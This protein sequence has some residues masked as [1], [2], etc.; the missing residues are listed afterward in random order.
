MFS[1]KNKLD[2]ELKYSLDNNEY[3]SYRVLI[4]YK[5]LK[6]KIENKIN[7]YKGNVFHNISCINT[8][9]ASVSPYTLNRLIEHPEIDYICFDKMAL[10]CGEKQG[11]GKAN[12]ISLNGNYRLTGKGIGIGLIDTGVYPHDDL[13]NPYKKVVQFKD[14][15]NGCKYPYDDN[16]HGTFISGLLCGSGYKSDGEFKGIAENSHIYCIKAFNA[17]GR[18]FVSDILFSIQTLI[19]ESEAH[20]IR[21]ICLPFEIIENSNFILSLFYEIF[22]IANEKGITIVVPSGH[23]GNTENSIRGI[24]TLN[25]CITVGGINTCY[26]YYKPYEFSSCGPYKKSEKPNVVAACVN[27]GSLNS[28]TS[29]YPERNGMKIYAKHL[30]NLYTSYTGTSCATAYVCGLCSLLLE[31]NPNLKFNDLLS[32]LQVSSKLLNMPKHIQGHGIIDVD[33]LLP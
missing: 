3:K 31:N 25:N 23:N 4:H 13:I 5:N 14:L 18:G 2:S 7:R 29:Y 15:I 17:V 1:F 27:I 6:G 20:N 19:E 28:D 26:G 16:G 22:K 8:F 10:V 33:K 32:L 11:I 21:L 24:A 9:C 30:E 12:K